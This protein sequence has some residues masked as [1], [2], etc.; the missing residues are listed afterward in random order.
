MWV[1]FFILTESSAL[2]VRLCYSKLL[3]VFT[4][5]GIAYIFTE[6]RDVLTY[7]SKKIVIEIAWMKQHS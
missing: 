5:C 4:K 2:S 3:A 7:H 6:R 1:Q